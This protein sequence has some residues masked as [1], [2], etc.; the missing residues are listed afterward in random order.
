MKENYALSPEFPEEPNLELMAALFL[1]DLGEEGFVLG[2]G[3]SPTSR[4]ED[5][6]DRSS[7]CTE[8]FTQLTLVTA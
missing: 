7:V 3:A 4:G 5:E 6:S 1:E 8:V 2:V